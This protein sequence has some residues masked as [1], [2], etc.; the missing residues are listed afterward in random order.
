MIKDTK[1]LSECA[2]FRDDR[3]W[4]KS[5]G[6][7]DRRTISYGVRYYIYGNYG[8]NLSFI[9]VWIYGVRNNKSFAF[10]VIACGCLRVCT[11]DHNILVSL[12]IHVCIYV[13]ICICYMYVYMCICVRTRIQIHRCPD[14]LVWWAN[15]CIYIYL[16]VCMYYFNVTYIHSFSLFRSLLFSLFFLSL[17]LAH[18]RARA[19][20]NII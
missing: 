1:G 9:S 17:S 6:C 12:Y 5:L 7:T 2:E 20:G 14:R 8:N 10:S 19:Y 11:L 13:C 15:Q 4:A 16:S 18:A 3:E